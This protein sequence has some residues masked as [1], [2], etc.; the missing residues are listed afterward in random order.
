[1]LIS[2]S[3]LSAGS[4]KSRDPIDPSKTSTGGSYTLVV[5]GFDWGPGVNKV[6]LSMDEEVSEADPGD[7]NVV[8]SRSS[9]CVVVEGDEATGERTVIHAY[10]SDEKGNFMESGTYVTLVLFVSPRLPLSSPF[11]YVRNEQCRGNIWVDYQLTITDNKTGMVWNKETGRVRELC[12]RFDL[13]GSYQFNDE[14]T[15]SYASYTPP[16]NKEKSPL[17]IWLHGGGEGGTDPSVP[18]LANRAANYASDDIQ[19]IFKGAYVLV[20]QCPGAWMQNARGVMTHGEEDDAYHV[21]LMALI[22]DYVKNHPDIDADRIYVGGCS[23]GGYMSLKLI[24]EHPGYFAAG[25]ISALAYQSQ[26]ITDEQ[27]ENI[28]N[29]PIWFVQSADDPTTIP[30]KTVIPV[31]KRLI[32][33]GAGNVHFS[34]YDHVVDITG[35]YGGEDY[36]YNGHWSWVYCHANLCRW[37]YDGSPVEVE[38]RPVTIMEWLAAQ[39]K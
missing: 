18:L 32:G 28:K 31:Y 39:S 19:A 25:Y 17:I 2:A 26:Y 7:Y 5:K 1:M 10:V 11:K 35:F 33:A 23:N 34:F 8:A 12:D 36:H 9:D 3:V 30:E 37:D 21:G 6:V 13:S 14:L 24:L 15:M 4:E 38:G 22:K 27:I 20:P 29:V 16:G